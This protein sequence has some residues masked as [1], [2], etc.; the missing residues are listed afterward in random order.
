M[1][2]AVI[3]LHAVI[4]AKVGIQPKIAFLRIDLSILDCSPQ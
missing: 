3:P 2:T 1:N 4:P